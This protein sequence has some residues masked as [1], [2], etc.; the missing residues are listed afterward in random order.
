MRRGRWTF[1]AWPPRNELH[2]VARSSRPRRRSGARRCAWRA[3]ARRSGLYLTGHPDRARRAQQLPR[4]VSHR[5]GDLLSERPY[6][7]EPVRSIGGGRAG[8]ASPA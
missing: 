2:R 6:R 3:S 7:P 8:D 4:F 5:I 1:S